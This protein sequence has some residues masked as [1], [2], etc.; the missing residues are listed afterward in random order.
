MPLTGELS[1]TD[2][3]PVVGQVESLP[4]GGRERDRDG[5]VSL[6]DLSPIRAVPER[7]SLDQYSEPR[8][9]WRVVLLCGAPFL[10]N[11]DWLRR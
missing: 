1:G 7:P 8:R 9:R 3:V 5:L 11:R 6:T 2:L 10:V 4:S